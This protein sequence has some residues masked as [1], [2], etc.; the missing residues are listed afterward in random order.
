[1]DIATLVG[2]VLGLM[3]IIISIFVSGDLGG[4]ISLPS[5]MIV[6]G[7][8]FAATLVNFPLSTVTDV[9]KIV[10]NA[11]LHKA[12][13][14]TEVIDAL[15]RLA[16]RA[17][18][19]GILAIEKQIYEIDDPFMR[20]GIQLAVDGSEPEVIRNIMENELTNLEGRHKTGQSVLH[21]MGTFAPAFGMIGTL[22]G[23]I[24][25]LRELEDPTKIGIGMAI[26]L[27]TTFY[28]ALMANLVFLPLEGKLKNR[29]QDEVLKR[30]MVIE[31]IL[32]IQSGDNPRI[33][34]GKLLTFIA[35]K[36]RKSEEPR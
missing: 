19:E 24:N 14:V 16:E 11:F 33:V 29:T 35:P 9:F 34:R 22:I 28:G 23:L 15:V 3:L 13:S 31:G 7:G 1:M 36:D 30:E 32:S 4:F 26:A 20:D 2:I 17:R 10:K 27:V 5:M 18:R 6:F 12:G 25:M 21:A 8:T